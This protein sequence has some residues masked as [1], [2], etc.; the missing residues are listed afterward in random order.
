MRKTALW[1]LLLITIPFGIA[2]AEEA[3]PMRDGQHDFDFYVG[4]WKIHNRRLV[5]PLTGS[6]QW[7]EFDGT[8]VARPVWNGRANM[9]EYEG[10]S[11]SGHISGLTVRT[12]NAKT[13]QWSLYWANASNGEFSL[14]PVVGHFEN[15][16]GEFFDHEDYN[17]K[18]IVVRYT[19][20]DISADH[21]RWEQAFSPDGGKTWETNWIMESTRIK[22]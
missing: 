5:K 16:R 18:P 17:G 11:P 14:P 6:K 8:S 21:C 7:I 20:S 4:T 3:K 2:R 13:G 10:E 12:Y 9:D 1:M 19:W 15:G 22:E